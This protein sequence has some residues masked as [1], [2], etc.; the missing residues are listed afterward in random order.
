MTSCPGFRPAVRPYGLFRTADNDRELPVKHRYASLP[1]SAVKRAR[2]PPSLPVS[3]AF[4]FAVR[5]PF[6]KDCVFGPD[7]GV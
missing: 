6:L 1:L 2:A 3:A 4:A 5:L 7:P